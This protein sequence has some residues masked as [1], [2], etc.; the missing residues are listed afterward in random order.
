[1][2]KDEDL[3]QYVLFRTCMV[4]IMYQINKVKRSRDT[5]AVEGMTLVFVTSNCD[6]SGKTVCTD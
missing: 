1:M 4:D 3:N 6:I 5:F 2:K